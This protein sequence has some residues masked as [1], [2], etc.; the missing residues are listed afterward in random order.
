[1]KDDSTEAV[2]SDDI[3]E[4]GYR[5]RVYAEAHREWGT[6]R[7]L[8]GCKGWLLER[9]IPGTSWHDATCCY[10]LF[11]CG[12]WSRLEEDVRSPGDGCVSV[13]MVT[14]PFASVA[15][16]DLERCFTF[17]HAW[18]EH[19]VVDLSK[20][21]SH[22]LPVRHRRNL[23]TA[24]RHVDVEVCE[25]PEDHLEEWCR[26]YDFLCR[27]HAVKGHRAFSQRSFAAQLR[28]PGVV[29]LRAHVGEAVVGMH[30]WFVDRDIAYGHLGA[31]SQQGYEAMASYPLYATAIEHFSR[32][33]SW[34]S[35][36]AAPGLG[37]SA[38]SGLLR[39]KRGWATGV[40]PVFFCGKIVDERRYTQLASGCVENS[41]FFPRYR[42]GE[43]RPSGVGG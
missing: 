36:G 13:S 14:D 1:M 38:D 42:A 39:F 15:A 3:A 10:P 37:Q 40:K 21:A 25:Q 33:L 43:G 12:D 32:T 4:M 27:R 7:H 11:A 17:V 28:T 29:M 26:L 22:I 2:A 34:A 23:A 24:A 41:F 31:T 9:S 19:L 5:S 18:K 35:L 16:D 6:P 30:L 20:R 8:P